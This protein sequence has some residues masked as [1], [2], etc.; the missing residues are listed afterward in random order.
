[1]KAVVQRVKKASVTIG[2]EIKSSI[3]AGLLV[4]IA[5]AE[6]D[7]DEIIDWFVNKLINLRIFDD[8]D[9][10]MNK[11]ILDT[12]GEMLIVSNFTIYGETKKG[13]RPSYSNA[14]PPESAKL[15]YNKM[16]DYIK[17]SYDFTFKTGEFGA[18]MDVE[19]VNDGPVTLIIEKNNFNNIS[20]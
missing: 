13:F 3:N 9:G 12:K 5:I 11:S 1:M 20:E 8:E 17:S 14:C 16:L 2:G 4:L 6:F 15:I 18:M 7:N 19:L 10:K